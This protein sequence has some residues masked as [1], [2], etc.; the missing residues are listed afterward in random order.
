MQTEKLLNQVRLQK[1]MLQ[2][3][4]NKYKASFEQHEEDK[5][6]MQAEIIKLSMQLQVS[7]SAELLAT[8]VLQQVQASVEQNRIGTDKSIALLT[9][10]RDAALSKSHKLGQENS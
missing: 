2:K 9:S 10:Q 7:Q 1:D 5:R 6:S 8:T 3:S 4:T